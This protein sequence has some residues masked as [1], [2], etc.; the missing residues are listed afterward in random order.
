[1]VSHPAIRVLFLDVGGVLL[2]NG[3]DRSMR[4]LAAEKFQL[5]YADLDERHH[6]TFDTFESGKLSLEEYLDRTIFFRPRPFSREEFQ[7]FMLSQ[8]KAY[9]ET[10]EWVR[11]LKSRNGLKVAVVSN[12][13][14]ELTVHRVRTFGL[15]GFVDFFVVSCFVHFRKPDK[16]IYRMALDI[17]QVSPEE[18]AYVDD[19]LMFVEVA[20]S[21]GIR[22][23]H[24]T[25]L[26][27][28]KKALASWGLRV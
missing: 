15:A 7:S 24:H 1:M 2:T 6:L 22:G 18:A 20:R 27:S 23:V 8:S 19:R 10:I 13:G 28:T 25:G 5:D 14:R 11:V 12:E 4:R 21:L 9:P 26:E 3:W 17:A 16:D